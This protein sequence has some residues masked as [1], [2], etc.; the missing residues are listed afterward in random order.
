MLPALPPTFFRENAPPPTHVAGDIPC[1][2]CGYNLRTLLIDGP[3]S[4]CGKP[5]GETLELLK[6]RWAESWDSVRACTHLTGAAL[7]ICLVVFAIALVE[8]RLGFVQSP[9][10]FLMCFLVVGVPLYVLASV[11]MLVVICN[12]VPITYRWYK[13]LPI[14]IAIAIVAAQMNS[15]SSAFLRVFLLGVMFGLPAWS[16]WHI[17]RLGRSIGATTIVKLAKC[18]L[19]LGRIAFWLACTLMITPGKFPVDSVGAGA[20]VLHLLHIV[21]LWLTA[22]R[23]NAI[24]RAVRSVENTV[25]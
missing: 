16:A 2:E 22:S 18:N 14:V 23:L 25:E 12:V 20:V 11:A 3:C 24:V 19:W 6:S 9:D 5:V 17:V 1:V 8:T 13:L 10:D 4:E 7:A 15:F 21:V